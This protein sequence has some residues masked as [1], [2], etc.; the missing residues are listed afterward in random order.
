MKL[1][2]IKYMLLTLGAALLAACS[3]DGEGFAGDGRAI[4]L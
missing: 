1:F 3:S 4:D 2:S